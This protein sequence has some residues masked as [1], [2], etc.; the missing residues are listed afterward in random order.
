MVR[1]NSNPEKKTAAR[2]DSRAAV[3]SQS[4]FT[5]TV[6]RADST[7]PPPMEAA[8]PRVSDSRYGMEYVLPGLPSSLVRL[9]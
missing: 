7:A 3:H 2:N 1:G 6:R 5:R 4:F 8:L 9:S